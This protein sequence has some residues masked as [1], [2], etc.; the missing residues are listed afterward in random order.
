MR[1]LSHLIIVL[2]LFLV[3]LPLTVAAKPTPP[4]DLMKVFSLFLGGEDFVE[5]DNWGG[6]DKW[7]DDVEKQ[8]AK[9]R[10]TMSKELPAEDL[11][12]FEKSLNA[13]RGSNA[14]KQHERNHA[15]F[16][17]LH[18]SFLALLDKFDYKSPPLMYLV[19]NDLN[20]VSAALKSGESD[21]VADELKEVE[22]FYNQVIPA[23]RARGMDNAM[24]EEFKAQQVRCKGALA[25]NDR[26]LLA[27][28]LV[29]LQQLLAAQQRALSN[30]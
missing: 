25:S 21:E 22:L 18:K 6:V 15:Q 7:L 11:A 23:L 12:T 26:K 20:E 24:I 17:A 16:L 4:A 29:K 9:L 13:L 2:L 14:A 3:L 5:D 10:P 8:Y 19:Q 27:A 1:S 30:N 28:E